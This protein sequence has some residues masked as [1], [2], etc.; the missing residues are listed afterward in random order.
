MPHPWN[1]RAKTS[2]TGEICSQTIAYFRIAPRCCARHDCLCLLH[3]IALR[4][5][6]R[7]R[8]RLRRGMFADPTAK[9]RYKSRPDGFP[10]WHVRPHD[11]NVFST[12]VCAR[13]SPFPSL[14][15][16]DMSHFHNKRIS[17]YH[18][19][20][21]AFSLMPKRRRCEP[22]VCLSSGICGTFL[23]RSML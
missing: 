15:E 9:S 19:F 22:D 2:I 7:R 16:H 8:C 11:A 1:H 4:S 23:S 17:G 5:V 18:D 12:L 14:S 3:V 6:S 10:P 13:K 20:E 21:F